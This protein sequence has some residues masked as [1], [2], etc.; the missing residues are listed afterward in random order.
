MVAMSASWREK[1]LAETKELSTV[2]QLVDWM[3]YLMAV[4]KDGMKVELRAIQM[5]D[6]WEW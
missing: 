5:A 2:V 4:M 6:K 1:T 3:V